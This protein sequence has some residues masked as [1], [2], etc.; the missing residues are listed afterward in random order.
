MKY[1]KQSSKER[2]ARRIRQCRQQKGMKQVE[3]DE[4]LGFQHGIIS[5]YECQKNEPP[6]YVLMNIANVLG[7]SMDY[8]C[9]ITTESKPYTHIQYRAQGE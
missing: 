5:T 8:L 4:S 1:T 3:L 9:G 6:V 2:I 7:V